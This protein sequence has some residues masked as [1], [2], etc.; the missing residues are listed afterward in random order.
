M[1]KESVVGWPQRL[2]RAKKN[3]P[4]TLVYLD[5]ANKR[6]PIKP[7]DCQSLKAAYSRAKQQGDSKIA[8]SALRR[9]M[10]ARCDWAVKSEPK[11]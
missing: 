1:A 7:G 10:S 5:E 4:G 9:A 8:A 11:G 6:Y 3:A 2:K